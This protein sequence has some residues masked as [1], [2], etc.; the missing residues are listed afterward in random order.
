MLG[1]AMQKAQN[2]HINH[3]YAIGEDQQNQSTTSST[4]TLPEFTIN[5][6]NTRDHRGWNR[7]QHE[8]G[9]YSQ[10]SIETSRQHGYNKKVTSRKLNGSQ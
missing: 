2:L 5:E 9:D 4:D 7:N 8:N 10:N 1:E 3:L 6:L